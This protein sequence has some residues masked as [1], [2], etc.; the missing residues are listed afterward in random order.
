MIA[1][2]RSDRW[3]GLTGGKHRF[4]W[5]RPWTSRRS[6]AED[7]RRDRMACV[8]ANRGAVPGC[9]FNEKNF[10]FPILPSRGVYRLKGIVV[11]CHLFGTRYILENGGR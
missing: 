3:I 4:H 6:E 2:D 11:I 5:W 8:E 10:K 7:T 9:P 1:P